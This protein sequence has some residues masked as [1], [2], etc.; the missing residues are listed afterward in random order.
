MIKAILGSTVLIASLAVSQAAHSYDSST[1]KNVDSVQAKYD[2]AGLQSFI[3]DG[4]APSGCGDDQIVATSTTPDESL[5]A[6]LAI[7]LAAYA[8]G[9]R[10][11]VY[12]NNNS[13][14][15]CRWEYLRIVD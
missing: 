12:Y 8:S 3:L 2:S 1:T 11:K 4:G 9:K 6:A 5:E 10:L 14:G 13:S 15:S 7:A